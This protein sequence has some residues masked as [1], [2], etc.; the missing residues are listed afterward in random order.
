MWIRIHE[1]KMLKV[2]KFENSVEN[3]RDLYFVLF[4][5][6]PFPGLA[7]LIDSDTVDETKGTVL[8]FDRIWVDPSIA[9]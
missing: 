9:R 1:Y 3:I 2:E 7:T 4:C 6:Q 8:V 5:Y